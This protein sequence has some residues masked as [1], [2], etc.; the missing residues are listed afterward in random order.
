MT[1]CVAVSEQRELAGVEM[2]APGKAVE[3]AAARRAGEWMGEEY[4]GSA[5]VELAIV[6]KYT[7]VSWGRH[8]A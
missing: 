7:G 4:N 3:R 2:R 5:A 6:Q 1:F 8:R